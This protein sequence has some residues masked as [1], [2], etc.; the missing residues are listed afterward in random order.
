LTGKFVKQNFGAIRIKNSKLKGLSQISEL[1][2]SEKWKNLFK[3]VNLIWFDSGNQEKCFKLVL[4][5]NF[6]GVEVI[7]PTLASCEWQNLEI[8]TISTVK[9]FWFANLLN[10][11]RL[12]RMINLNQ[13]FRHSKRKNGK[14]LIQ[15]LWTQN[16]F[17]N[18]VCI[19]MENSF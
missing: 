13:W 6:F 1:F 16:Y 8:S 18:Y 4:L 12:K 7:F 3:G 2:L 14:N 19:G 10:I 15:L 5:L 11:F 17:L 9:C